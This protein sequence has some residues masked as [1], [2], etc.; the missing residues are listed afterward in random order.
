[1]KVKVYKHNYYTGETVDICNYTYFLEDFITAKTPILTY[2]KGVTAEDII[3]DCPE[4]F[5][6]DHEKELRGALSRFRALNGDVCVI[7][8][9]DETTAKLQIVPNREGISVYSQIAEYWGYDFECHN[10]L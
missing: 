5:V 3:A 10:V 6:D 7:I 1:M 4:I 8:F 2:K 9:Y